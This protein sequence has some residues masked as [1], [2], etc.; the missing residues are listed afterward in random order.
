MSRPLSARAVSPVHRFIDGRGEVRRTL[1]RAEVSQERIALSGFGSQ[2]ERNQM[3]DQAALG[4]SSCLGELSQA[5]I[6]PDGRVADP[7]PAW[8]L[9]GEIIGWHAAWV[10]RVVLSGPGDR[11]KHCGRG[12]RIDSTVGYDG[13]VVEGVE[14]GDRSRGAHGDAPS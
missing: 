12:N 3:D 14:P 8:C 11:I 13:I 10:A 6:H 1:D 2:S 4:R 7:E 5:G 9:A